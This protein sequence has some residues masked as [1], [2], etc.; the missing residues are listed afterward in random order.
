[1]YTVARKGKKIGSPTASMPRLSGRSR[2]GNNQQLRSILYGQPGGTLPEQAA[3]HAHEDVATRLPPEDAVIPMESDVAVEPDVDSRLEQAGMVTAGAT[4]MGQ[5]WLGSTLGQRRVATILRPSQ[6]PETMIAASALTGPPDRTVHSAVTPGG[7]PAVNNNGPDNSCTPS[8]SSAVLSWSVISA[9]AANWAVQ[10][11]SLTLSGQIN[12]NPW[13]SHANSMVVPNT[14]NPVD[15]GNIN[16][17][18]GSS[19]HWQAVIQDMADYDTAGGGAGPNW[20]STA[21]SSAHENAHWS[22]D[23]V[24]D[25]VT[26]A[27]GGNWPT[28]NTDLDALR[29]PK[30]GSATAADARTALAPRVDARLGTW[31][32]ATIARWSAIPDSPGGGDTGYVAGTRVLNGLIGS[33]RSY[34][35]SKGW[36]KKKAP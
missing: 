8:T 31:R 6:S 10:V 21:A 16:N 4:T 2:A 9:D 29:E 26:S 3:L 1:M 13:P 20:H 28:T 5:G 15:G 35:D 33:V 30:A 18:A 25:A 24:A 19:N 36:T 12:I 27:A 32:A 23:Y 14:P 17:T 7:T 11:D 22:Q 34:A